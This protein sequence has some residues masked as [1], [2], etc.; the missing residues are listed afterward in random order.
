MYLQL[1]AKRIIITDKFTLKQTDKRTHGQTDSARSIPH[2]ILILIQNKYALKSQRCLTR[3]LYQDK[4]T[5]CIVLKTVQE[6]V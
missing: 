6:Y 4:H 3:F 1:A 5:L 2:L